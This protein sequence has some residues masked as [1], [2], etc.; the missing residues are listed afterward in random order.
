MCGIELESQRAPQSKEA[1]REM[2]MNYVGTELRVPADMG[3]ELVSVVGRGVPAG[4]SCLSKASEMSCY[5]AQ[6]GQRQTLI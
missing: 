3:Q 4:S 6:E 5:R 1:H 2:G